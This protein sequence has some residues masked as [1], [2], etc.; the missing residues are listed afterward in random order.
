MISF[1]THPK[2]PMFSLGQN[3]EARSAVKRTGL[4]LSSEDKRGLLLFHE[5]VNL[6]F[7]DHHLLVGVLTRFG[8]L[9]GL[10][11]FDII[12][13]GAGVCGTLSRPRVL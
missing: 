6:V 2:W 5:L 13:A 8:V 3:N 1:I 4:R 10:Y 12:A 7:V 9:D 11:H